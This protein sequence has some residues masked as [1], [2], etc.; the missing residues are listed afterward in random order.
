MEVACPDFGILTSDKGFVVKAY[1]RD[2]GTV[3][4]LPLDFYDKGLEIVV[5]AVNRS[6]FAPFGIAGHAMIFLNRA[7]FALA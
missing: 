4:A 6:F 1:R 7:F 3:F 5:I 2:V